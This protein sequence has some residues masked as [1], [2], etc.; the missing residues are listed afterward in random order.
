MLLNRQSQLA[1]S[2]RRSARGTSVPGFAEDE[3]AIPPRDALDKPTTRGGFSRG[4][5]ERVSGGGFRSRLLGNDGSGAGKG[6]A[7][8]TS[9]VAGALMNAS[10]RETIRN[11]HSPMH[12]RTQDPASEC[13]ELSGL[14]AVSHLRELRA[15]RRRGRGRTLGRGAEGR[16]GTG[17]SASSEH[18]PLPRTGQRPQVRKSGRY[19][20]Y[21]R[22]AS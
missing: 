13:S 3:G 17:R 20:G 19:G 1:R 16:A 6:R 14:D 18:G 8:R 21:D 11:E 12:A 9:R 2:I 15:P 4:R 5:G 22:S 10:P 7:L